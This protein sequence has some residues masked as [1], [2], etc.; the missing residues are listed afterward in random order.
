MLYDI[1]QVIKN[2][3]FPK[4]DSQRWD[5]KGNCR[6]K[7]AHWQGKLISWKQNRIDKSDTVLIA[8]MKDFR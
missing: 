2:T 4:D 1:E 7:K 3:N 6:G 5:Y 8:Y